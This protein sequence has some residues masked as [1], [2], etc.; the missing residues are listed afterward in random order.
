M[1]HEYRTWRSKEVKR[2]TLANDLRTL[3]KFLEFCATIDAVEPGMRERVLIPELKPGDEISGEE[4][5]EG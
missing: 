1:L 2:V 4:L 5:D 3:Q